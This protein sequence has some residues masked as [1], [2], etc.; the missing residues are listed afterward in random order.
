MKPSDDAPEQTRRATHQGP[1]RTAGRRVST[2]LVAATFSSLFAMSVAVGLA[3]GCRSKAQPDV[4]EAG[5]QEG[6]ERPTNARPK[7]SID[8]SET[9]TTDDAGSSARGKISDAPAGPDDSKRSFVDNRVA[10]ALAGATEIVGMRV[11]HCG[12]SCTCPPPCI[13]TVSAET[14]MTW[15]DLH[16]DGGDDVALADWASA[17]VTGRFTGRTRSVPAIGGEG[18]PIVLPE[19]RLTSTPRVVGTSASPEGEG[20]R[21]QVILEGAL[22]NKRIARVKD[23]KPFLVV[24]G[25]F[26]LSDPLRANDDASALFQKIDKLGIHDAE[27]YDSRAFVGLACCF[28]VVLGGRFADSKAADVRAKQLS[29]R[30]VKAYAKRGF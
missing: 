10:R 24:A 23:D 7:A 25:A 9:H 5:A 20:S 16:D 8:T 13:E 27:R 11:W 28:D 2:D 1:G 30:G 6:S 15:I 19:V 21:A 12:P 17:D 26:S 3:G 14:G 4:A 18:P 22:A 29:A